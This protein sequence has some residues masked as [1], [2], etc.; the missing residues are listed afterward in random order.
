ML[1]MLLMLLMMINCCHHR[2]HHHR[3]NEHTW[4][5]LMTWPWDNYI[6]T[7]VASNL[8][9]GMLRHAILYSQQK[10]IKSAGFPNKLPSTKRHVA[11][12]EFKCDLLSCQIQNENGRCF[13]H[14]QALIGQLGCKQ[15]THTAG[16]ET[17]KILTHG[18]GHR[19]GCYNML[20]LQWPALWL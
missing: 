18:Q 2:C 11:F 17:K 14:F 10:H 8:N 3:P 1:M 6:R 12:E 4:T 5:T 7:N 9:H 19:F 16:I 13:K 20:Q 15:I